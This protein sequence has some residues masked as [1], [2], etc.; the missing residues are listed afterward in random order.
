M[1]NLWPLIILGFVETNDMYATYDL[2]SQISENINKF[3]FL[4]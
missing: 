1:Q 2:L 4:S 3:V